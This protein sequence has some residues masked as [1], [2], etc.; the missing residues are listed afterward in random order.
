MIESITLMTDRSDL[1]FDLKSMNGLFKADSFNLIIGNNGAGKTF[2][3]KNIAEAICSNGERALSNGFCTLSFK[4]VN[5]P[6][7]KTF[8]ERNSVAS[9]YF[10]S[11]PYRSQFPKSSQRFKNAALYANSRFLPLINF[12]QYLN[13]ASDLEMTASPKAV[14][15]V[16][17]NLFI[18]TLLDALLEIEEHRLPNYITDVL[19]EI[20]ELER[21]RSGGGKAESDE[22]GHV[23]HKISALEKNLGDYITHEMNH[24]FEPI[25]QI[26][27]IASFNEVI[28]KARLRTA[29]CLSFLDYFIFVSSST[30]QESEA[31][32]PKLI[33][34]LINAFYTRLSLIS[35]SLDFKLNDERT[36]LELALNAQNINWYRSEKFVKK[37]FK[38]EW[39]G[40]SSGQMAILN[41]F[42]AIEQNIKLLIKNEKKS[43]LLLIDEGDIFLH[44]NWQ[45][46]YIKLLD[47][48]IGVLKNR[49]ENL[50]I[51]VLLTT[52][53]PILL[54]DVPSE[55][56]VNLNSDHSNVKSF[57]APVQQIVNESFN[58]STLG[59]FSR[60]VLQD[61][62]S[63]VERGRVPVNYEY[64]L[65]IIDDP[66]IETEIKRL[67][68][69]ANT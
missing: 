6:I 32:L 29:L 11:I 25:Q 58:T 61:F 37:Y 46:K 51:Q 57:A 48:F 34:N 44:L 35:S 4:S 22:L 8:T 5:T 60:K 19:N 21:G 12:E 47:D 64:L 40:F 9:I 26:A 33:H 49:H 45:R 59:E 55:A 43:I 53:S 23:I 28:P 41:Q 16:S 42:S 67:M 2:V 17:R 13:L 66:I 3:L 14:M 20:H 68:A 10:T 27:L 65:S 52:H 1:R 38:L 62:I 56:I 50:K 7:T 69:K 31:K 39:D 54:T 36:R 24:L 15:N 30:Y 63:E 18:R